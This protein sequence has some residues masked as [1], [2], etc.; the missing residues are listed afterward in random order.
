MRKACAAAWAIREIH[1]NTQ[2]KCLPTREQVS[3]S[4][5]CLLVLVC[6]I[7][8]VRQLLL[9][10]GRLFLLYRRGLHAC[11][12]ACL[13]QGGMGPKPLVH[14]LLVRPRYFSRY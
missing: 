1:H 6:P 8:H 3:W 12:P 2:R 13:I 9:F 14:E 11:L 7:Q 10:Y 5:Q 4:A